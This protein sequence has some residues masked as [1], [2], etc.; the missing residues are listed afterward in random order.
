MSYFDGIKVG[1]RVF[2]VI[3][4]WGT[5]VAI[6][7]STLPVNVDFD[8]DIQWDFT[9]DGKSHENDFGQSL[10]WDEVKITPP[11]R[12]KHKEKKKLVIYGNIVKGVGNKFIGPKREWFLH[13]TYEDAETN[14]NNREKIAIAKVTIEWEE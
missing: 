8:N 7:K 3:N 10:F 6:D 9:L 13:K 4:G 2:H 14:D 1:D 11:P 12:P 5:V